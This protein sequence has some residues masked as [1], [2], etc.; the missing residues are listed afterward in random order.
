MEKYRGRAPRRRRR[1]TALAAVVAGAL[2][3]TGCAGGG[4]GADKAGA[5]AKGRPTLTIWAD[6]QRAAALK[7][8]AASFGKKYGTEVSVQAVSK[9]LQATFL[10]AS[11]AGTGPDVVVGANDWIGNLVQNGAIDPVRL[12]GEQKASLHERSVQAVTFNGQTYG[13][14]YALE[15]VAL[16]RNTDLVPEAPAT[17]EEAVEIG[18]RLKAEG[19]TSEI[20]SVP[21][22]QPG[23]A[24]HGYAL[25]SSAGGYLFGRDKAGE[26][27]P[28]ELGLGTEASIR[29]FEKFRELGEKGEGALKRSIGQDNA[30]PTFAS[31]KAPFLLSGPWSVPDV[32]K[33][34]VNYEIQ[35]VPPFAGHEAGGPFIGVQAF[36]VAAKSHNKA[37][38]QEFVAEVGGSPEASIALTEANPRPPALKVALDHFKDSNPDLRKFLDAGKNG[39]VQPAIPEM[40]VVWD[41]FGKA[42]A[43]VIGGAEVRP[44][45]EALAKAV[46]DQLGIEPPVARPDADQKD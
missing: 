24:Y 39:V 20:M 5:A 40:N 13:M 14:P 4:A 23:D 28:E 16:L 18:K 33:A 8:F 36:Y 21:V 10:T 31:G 3:V 25:Y 27:L 32:K 42:Q 12:S 6:D 35:A 41:P 19:R 11:Q 7:G 29:A 9:E 46:A 22:G 2:V 1:W 15:N 43:A 17:F 30:I 26:Y 45:V 44:T 38:A 37:L 34:G